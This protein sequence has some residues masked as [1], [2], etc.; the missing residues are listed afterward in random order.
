MKNEELG[1]LSY[2]VPADSLAK[3]VETG[4][5]VEFADTVATSAAAQI[6]A[7]IIDQVSRAAVAGKAVGGLSIGAINIFDGGDFGTVPRGPK[8]PIPRVSVAFGSSL[9]HVVNAA[10]LKSVRG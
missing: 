4:R 9:S 8:I 1:K 6:R 2:E 3:V 5:L 10:G 7:Q